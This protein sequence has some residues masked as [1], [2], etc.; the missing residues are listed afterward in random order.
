[1]FYNTFLLIFNNLISMKKFVLP[2][3]VRN[4]YIIQSEIKKLYTFLSLT[5]SAS[6]PQDA[7]GVTLPFS[8]FR[9]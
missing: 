7:H 4:L 1:M 5:E 6:A 8:A 3:S 2:I 9:N